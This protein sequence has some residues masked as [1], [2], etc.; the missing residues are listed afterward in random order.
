VIIPAPLP[1]SPTPTPLGNVVEIHTAYYDQA[2]E[3]VYVNLRGIK[4]TVYIDECD[5]KAMHVV[6]QKKPG[7]Q[8]GTLFMQCKGERSGK[9]L[10][11]K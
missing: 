11:L 10:Y 4:G 8:Y 7:E 5:G 9:I 2:S 1:A 3:N 6:L